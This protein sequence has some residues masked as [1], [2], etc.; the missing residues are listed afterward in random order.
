MVSSV[1]LLYLEVVHCFSYTG[2]LSLRKKIVYVHDLR[3]C[4]MIVSFSCPYTEGWNGILPVVV[5]GDTHV[6]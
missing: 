4:N 6:Y 3:H 5:E 2:L 1:A